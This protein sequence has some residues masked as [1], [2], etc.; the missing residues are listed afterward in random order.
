MEIQTMILATYRSP[1]AR[2]YSMA[3]EWPCFLDLQGRVVEC[4]PTAIAGA[5]SIGRRPYPRSANFG[6]EEVMAPLE[7][8]WGKH[9]LLVLLRPRA[10]T[11]A[12]RM[13]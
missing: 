11:F 10:D 9:F 1:E 12:R 2:D 8:S 7:E 4:T 13:R 3:L 6:M 5:A